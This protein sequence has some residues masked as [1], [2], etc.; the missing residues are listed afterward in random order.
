MNSIALTVPGPPKGKGRPRSTR[1]GRVYTP[2][3]TVSAEQRIQGEWIAA[4]CPR[5]PDGPIS[6]DVTACMSRPQAHWRGLGAMSAQG[7]SQRY[8]LKTPDVDNL[9]KLAA[10]ALS[11]LAYSDDRLIVQAS[12]TRQW[13]LAGQLE[14]TRI[15]L[16]PLAGQMTVAA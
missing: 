14:H 13:A 2:A 9:L 7:R 8:P 15:V 3:D 6:M 12:V 16:Y 1:Q 4:G 11:G 10:D 5:L